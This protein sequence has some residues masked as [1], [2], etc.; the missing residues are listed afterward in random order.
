MKRESTPGP[1]NHPNLRRLLLPCAVALVLLASVRSGL[2]QDLPADKTADLSKASTVA[3]TV[4]GLE[5]NLDLA[6]LS[7]TQSKS[8]ESCP[9]VKCLITCENGLSLTMDLTDKMACYSYSSGNGCHSSGF[10]VCSDK[11]AAASC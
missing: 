4:S 7:S 11:P 3:T 5:A 2:A 9:S 1:V 6:G 8:M 10:F